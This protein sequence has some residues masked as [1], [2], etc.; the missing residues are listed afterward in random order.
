MGIIQ[1]QTLRSLKNSTKIPGSINSCRRGSPG[2]N[3]ELWGQ[4]TI[5]TR[6]QGRIYKGKK[7]GYT[8]EKNYKATPI[9]VI[10]LLFDVKR[11]GINLSPKYELV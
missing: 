4:T 1:N 5:E 3:A 6:P 2:R 11:E 8:H 10:V 9:G 7:R